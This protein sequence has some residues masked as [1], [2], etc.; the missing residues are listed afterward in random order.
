[1]KGRDWDGFTELKAK[2]SIEIY[3]NY[4]LFYSIQELEFFLKNNI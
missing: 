4:K 2:K 1:M 3:E